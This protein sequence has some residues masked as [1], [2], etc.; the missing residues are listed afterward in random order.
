[1]VTY[2]QV[3][4]TYF[5]QYDSIPMRL[6]VTSFYKIEKVNRGL[7]GFALVE[8]AVKPYI[9]DFCVGDDESVKRW[10]QRFDMSNWAFFMAFDGES[11]I[12]AAT[13]VSRTK[14]IHMLA[15]RDDLAVL[16]DIR[17]HDAYKGQGVGQ[18]LFD[19]AVNWS[20]GQKLS[21]MKIECQNNNVP[22]VKFYHKQGAILS[23]VDE[24]AYYNEPECRNEAQLI[25]YL[26]L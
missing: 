5:P 20:R 17:V 4:R 7:E 6:N 15:D 16:W 3:D 12:G 1:M 23:M 11:P 14:G 2:K 25:W 18:T 24:Y 19:M 22:A 21:Q 26:P 8:T 9:K 10:E 13:V